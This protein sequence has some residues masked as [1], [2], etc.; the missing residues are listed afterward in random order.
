MSE[1][2][3]MANQE[4]IS[5]VYS[6]IKEN[7]VK[8]VDFR[9]TDFKGKW[10]HITAP[11]A[12]LNDDVFESG[13]GFD[14][15]S[16]AGWCEINQSD[17]AYVPDPTTAVLDPFTEVPTLIFICDVVDPYTGEGYLR[18]PRGVAK[19]AEA[20]LKYSGLGDTINVGP[21][22]EF[23]IFDSARFT[24]Q[25]MHKVFYHIESEE[26]A[27][28]SGRD[29]EDGNYGHR[30]GIKGGY[31]PVP[32]TDSFQDMRSEMSSIMQEMGLTIEFHHHEVATAGQN[33]IDMRFDSLLS[34]ADDLQTFKY[35]V[36]NVAHA[37]GKTATFM[38]K[39]LAGD[40]GSGMHVHMSI[41]KD[42]VPLFA[43]NEYA[44]LSEMAL[45]FIG[46]IKKHARSLNAFTNPSTNSYKRLIPGFEA[47]VLLAHSARN[48][49]A[50]I[51]IPSS[52]NPK[53]KRAEIRFPD[54]T[55][56]GYLAFAAL[57][58]AGLDGIDNKIDPGAP[59]DKNLYDLPPEELK[60]IPTVCGSLR[61]ALNAL[62]EDREYLL[63]GDVFSDDL[64]DA[65]IKLKMDDVYAWEHAPHPVEFEMYYSV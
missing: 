57:L 65:W 23:F 42:G 58:M 14:G 11:A 32:P 31:F 46:G 59:M 17:M 55:A 16:I 45:H 43:G 49:S 24:S 33:E 41:W 29:F 20:Y 12:M 48:R 7:D 2:V 5:K 60:D 35:V 18:D 39:P 54:P 21:E 37:Y 25:D 4:A 10:Q 26:G 28:N 47:P 50:S 63:K 38:P 27:W 1:E 44:D 53:A 19:R 8:Y 30:P 9:F 15:S 6:M 51:R 56:N 34:M 64:I 36:H 22:A 52:N 61:E 40:N 62:S 3:S 13:L